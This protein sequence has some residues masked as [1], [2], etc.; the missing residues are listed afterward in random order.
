MNKYIVT[1]HRTPT[2]Y[3]NAQCYVVEAASE[4]D[5]FQIVKD[6]LRDFSDCGNYVYKVKTYTPPPQGR[7]ISAY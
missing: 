3:N 1:A 2:A 4:D 5:A 6:N 7:I